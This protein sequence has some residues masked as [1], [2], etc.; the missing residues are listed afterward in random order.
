MCYRLN[1]PEE[2]TLMIVSTV[3]IVPH[4]EEQDK[5]TN[6][7]MDRCEDDFVLYTF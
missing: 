4:L 2:I 6:T 5:W 7:Y 3:Q 1:L